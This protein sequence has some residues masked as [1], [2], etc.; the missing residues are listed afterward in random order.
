M[1]GSTFLLA[2]AHAPDAPH[3]E[4]SYKDSSVAFANPTRVRTCPQASS[5][6]MGIATHPPETS[7]SERANFKHQA[8]LDKLDKV[9]NEVNFSHVDSSRIHKQGIVQQPLRHSCELGAVPVEVQQTVPL[10][11]SL[12][13]AQA[14]DAQDQAA[15]YKDSSAA[16]P[17]SD[18][19]ATSPW[20]PAGPPCAPTCH[21]CGSV[22]K[23]MPAQEAARLLQRTRDTPGVALECMDRLR[24]GD[25]CTFKHGNPLPP[26]VSGWH[27]DFYVNFEPSEE[28]KRIH[29][30]KSVWE[31]Q[32]I[33]QK[34]TETLV[35]G[36]KACIYE[37]QCYCGKQRKYLCE[38]QDR[39]ALG[40]QRTNASR[41][42]F[43]DRKNLSEGFWRMFAAIEWED[44]R[45][46]S[47]RKKTT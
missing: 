9:A 3:R 16:C 45:V 47:K 29:A 12:G 2:Q 5:D 20:R 38:I 28:S 40:L 4:T 33:L 30:E 34:E 19:T 44:H 17:N 22:A 24:V 14:P 21:A 31:M 18:A 35:R 15:S 6:D 41:T 46:G 43:Q 39:K 25:R 32:A 36:Y 26:H 8:K 13:Q 11:L 27:R 7:T 1:L 37:L 10:L 42:K 23:A